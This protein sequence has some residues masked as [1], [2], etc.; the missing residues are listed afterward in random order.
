MNSDWGKLRR[1]AMQLSPA[2]Y[3][4]RYPAIKNDYH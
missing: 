4:E 2:G 3:A 1:F